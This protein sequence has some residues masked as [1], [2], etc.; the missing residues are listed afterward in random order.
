M[1]KAE[2]ENKVSVVA[3]KCLNGMIEKFVTIKDYRC[4]GCEK[5]PNGG[6]VVGVSEL[7]VTKCYPNL[8][9]KN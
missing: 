2:T 6:H 3:F 7:V 4:S 8:G 1:S 5:N 9:N